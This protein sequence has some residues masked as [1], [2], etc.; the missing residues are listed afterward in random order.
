MF[1]LSNLLLGVAK[2]LDIALT[3]YMWLIIIRAV[4]SWVN[5][6]PY[7]Q[8]VRLLHAATEPVLAPIRR[9][10][11]FVAGGLDL[12]PLLVLLAIVFL[13]AFVVRSLMQMA[14]H[15]T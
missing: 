11:P 13:K 3:V 7:N 2:V 1:L 8:I 5:P 12:S 14:M 4:L 6:D 15:L 9:R 10:V